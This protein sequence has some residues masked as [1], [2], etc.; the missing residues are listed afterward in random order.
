MNEDAK[1]KKYPPPTSKQSDNIASGQLAAMFGET[2]ESAKAIVKEK[3]VENEKK[4]G[5]R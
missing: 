5:S 1:K 3:K 4:K 2:I